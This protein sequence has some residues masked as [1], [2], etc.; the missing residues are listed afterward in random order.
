MTISL[1]F[2][3]EWRTALFVVI[4]VPVLAALGF[5]Q[6]ERAEEKMQIGAAFAQKQQMPAVG[7]TALSGASAEQLSYRQVKLTGEFLPER[8]FLLDNRMSK[9]RYGNEVLAL[10]EQQNTGELVLVNRGWVAADPARL[11][12]PEVAAVEGPVSI[13]G[14]V[15]VQ[16]GKPY[17]L[18]DEP[19]TDAWPKRIQSLD[20]EKL[21]A[22]LGEQGSR[23]FPYTVRI[24]DGQPGA[25]YAD[26]PVVNQSPEKHTGYAVQWFAMS[27][28]L[29]LLYLLRST[30][31][32]EIVRGKRTSSE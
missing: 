28:V 16:L 8:Y 27:F 29:A 20:I 32:M 23:L 9:G 24:A 3:S 7:L 4:M 15:Y 26:W 30:N 18:G 21:R 17:L 2:E 1:R 13:A 5:W 19:L 12:L 11:S 6:L 25:F 10:F 31:L 22:A 14:R